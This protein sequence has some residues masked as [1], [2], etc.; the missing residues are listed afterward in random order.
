MANK[1]LLIRNISYDKVR[2]T[3]VGSQSSVL[4]YYYTEAS[5]NRYYFTQV[6]ST[7]SADMEA[8]TFNAFLSFTMSGNVT[9]T[10][11]LIPMNY[12][13]TCMIETKVVGINSTGSK[14]YLMSSFGGFRHAGA[15]MPIIGSTINYTTKTDFTTASASFVASGTQSVVMR[16]QGQT[17]E[18]I[19][20]DIHINYI[21]GF[22]SLT[23]TS[24]GDVA[25]PIYPPPPSS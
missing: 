15:T 12:E 8:A 18:V 20:W 13:E 6:S 16:V 9:F 24:P 21:K 25:K 17:S 11:D 10:F 5:G 7:A 22:H 19:D 3:L 23:S 2:L 14:G 4:N 1:N